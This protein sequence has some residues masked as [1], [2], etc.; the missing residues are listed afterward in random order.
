[1]AVTLT[2]VPLDVLNE[3][4]LPLFDDSLDLISLASTCKYLRAAV[5]ALGVWKGIPRVA[6]A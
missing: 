3:R 4:F 2:D 6:L 5:A 1:M